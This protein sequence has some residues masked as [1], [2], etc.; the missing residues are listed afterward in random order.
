MINV[1][2]EQWSET[3]RVMAEWNT[4]DVD[5]LVDLPSVEICIQ[6]PYKPLLYEPIG[7]VCVCVAVPCSRSTSSTLRRKIVR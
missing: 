7:C 4:S 2:V 6:I 3:R 1:V 5:L